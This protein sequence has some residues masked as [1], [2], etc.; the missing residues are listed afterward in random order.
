MFCG[1]FVKDKNKKTSA[2]YF[3]AYP[4]IFRAWKTIVSFTI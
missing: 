1:W 2:Y 4:E 3:I